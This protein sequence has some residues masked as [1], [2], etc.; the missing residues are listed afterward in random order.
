MAEEG[1]GGRDRRRESLT[2][3]AQDSR[4]KASLHFM[5]EEQVSAAPGFSLRPRARGDVGGVSER[6]DTDDDDTKMKVDKRRG[7]AAAR[8]GLEKELM[9]AGAA[10]RRDERPKDSRLDDEAR[11][12]MKG[13]LRTRD[14]R[15]AWQMQCSGNDFDHDSAWLVVF[16]PTHAT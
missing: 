11:V 3:S 5:H 13:L 15:W 12:P 1:E 6:P 4:C 16:H 9:P 2:L 10:E 14:P 7:R 8:C